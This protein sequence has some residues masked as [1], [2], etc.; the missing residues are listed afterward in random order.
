VAVEHQVVRPVRAEHHQPRGRGHEEVEVVVVLVR[1]LAEV[2]DQ[3]EAGHQGAQLVHR[4]VV[5]VA[6][7]GA[8]AVGVLAALQ[9]AFEVAVAAAARA[10]WLAREVFVGEPEHIG[11][12]EAVHPPLQLLAGGLVQ[13]GEVGEAA[14]HVGRAF[15]HIV[16]QERDLAVRQLALEDQERAQ[17]AQDG[18]DQR[19]HADADQEPARERL[20]RPS[21]PPYPASSLDPRS[22]RPRNQASDFRRRM[23]GLAEHRRRRSRSTLLPRPAEDGGGGSAR[24][25]EM[26]GA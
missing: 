2:A 10:V 16:L 23:K 5:G 21:G 15:A 7:E 25:D 11:V 4:Q 19:H 1:G 14:V 17:R 13:G 12:A 8:H 9:G 18:H 20:H 6:D 3:L 22:F 24:S 26:E